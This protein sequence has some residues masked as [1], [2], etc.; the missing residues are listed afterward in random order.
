MAVFRMRICVVS[1]L[2]FV[3][4]THFLFCHRIRLNSFKSLQWLA[5]SKLYNTVSM[6]GD[7]LLINERSCM[8]RFDSVYDAIGIER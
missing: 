6:C 1:T 4:S 7:L 5:K 2:L 8:F 3:W